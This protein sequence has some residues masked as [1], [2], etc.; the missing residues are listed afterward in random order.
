M[1][2]FIIYSFQFSTSAD[3]YNYSVMFNNISKGIRSIKE[4][5]IY[6]IF[7][8]VG[9]LGLDFQFVYI[10]IYALSFYILYKSLRIYS[11]DFTFSLILYVFV[12]F[13]L[14]L[15]QIRQLLAVTISFAAYRYIFEKKFFRFFILI[16]LA[17]TCHVSALIMLPAYFLLRYRFKLSDTLFLVA[18]GIALGIGSKYILPTIIRKIA[19]S[20]LNWYKSFK[21]VGLL[22]WDVIL[23]AIFGLIVF[24]YGKKIIAKQINILFINAFMIYSIMYFCC[25]WIPEVKR[26]GYYY[27]FPIIALIPNCIA[28][29]KDKK[30]RSLYSILIFMYLC[31]YLLI[32]YRVQLDI[33]SV[34]IFFW[35]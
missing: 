17:S 26:W 5:T 20:R 12:F 15:H 31:I 14:T 34:N 8:L 23:L 7:K 22:K 4:P 28:A 21:D 16:L 1:P 27:F 11:S 13:A 35:K 2:L 30:I 3:Y 6:L 10:I 29:E 19:P 9:T 32:V 24:I 33:F 18:T 25:R